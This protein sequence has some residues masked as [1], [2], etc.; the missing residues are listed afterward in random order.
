MACPKSATQSLHNMVTSLALDPYMEEMKWSS[1]S[2]LAVLAAN[3][4][5]FGLAL[6]E[7]C[8]TFWPATVPKKAWHVQ[9]QPHT[10]FIA[11]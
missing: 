3:N 9:N 11:W 4:L 5:G 2:F 10:A 7:I 6:A 1:S 8:Q